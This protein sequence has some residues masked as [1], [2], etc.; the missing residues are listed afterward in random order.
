[1]LHTFTTTAILLPIHLKFSDQE[2]I[3][4]KSMNRALISAL[5][6]SS[7]NGLRLLWI[8]LI[9]MLWV[10][11]TWLYTLIWI[12]KGAFRYRSQA[13]QAAQKQA[14]DEQM[15]RFAP[16][17][18]PHHPFHSM[19]PL[20]EE[21]KNR[22]LKLRTVMVTN[23]PG[24]LRS[25]EELKEYFEYYMSRPLAKPSFGLVS[26]TQPGFVN[27][28]VTHLINR[29]RRYGFSHSSGDDTK[30]MI[31]GK[32]RT[33]SKPM[34]E[35]VV[36]ARKMTE[37]A[38]LLDR[39]EEAL[40]RLEAAHI[41]LAVNALSA[42]KDAMRM[43]QHGPPSKARRAAR[44]ITG[45]SPFRPTGVPKTSA[46]TDI[47]R[48]L[49]ISEE[50]EDS[51]EDLSELLTRTLAPYVE[52]DS[53]ALGLSYWERCQRWVKRTP[54]QTKQANTSVEQREKEIPTVWE[55]LFSLPRSTLNPYQPLIF[56]SALFRGQAVP[57]IDYYAQKVNYLTAKITEARSQSV[58]SFEAVSTAFVTFEDPR[59]ARRA[60]SYLAVHPDNPLACLVTMAPDYEDLDWVRLMKQTYKAE[61]GSKVIAVNACAQMSRYRFSKIGL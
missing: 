33:G 25:E 38:S 1:M 2:D 24:R 53:Y 37:L 19:P 5:I 48:G 29:L 43:K 59:E 50:E 17:P 22:G 36:L 41:K 54:T 31:E 9:L 35:R 47:E 4:S 26:S 20:E 18:H 44:R 15:N 3:P 14:E 61:V 27:K 42:V 58:R 40:R 23:I 46:E 34:I 39:R 55:A 12:S 16:H 51:P 30:S 6:N 45:F 8:H 28:I 10:T 32:A 49:R 21:K 7:N 56:L 11:L 57:A 52:L 13:I 60:C